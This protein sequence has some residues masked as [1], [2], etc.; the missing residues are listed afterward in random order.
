M[1]ISAD[2]RRLIKY[3]P[4]SPTLKSVV[5]HAKLHEMITTTQQKKLQDAL[6]NG[7]VAFF[8]YTENTDFFFTKNKKAGQTHFYIREDELNSIAIDA[9][10]HRSYGKTYD[11]RHIESD[12]CCLDH[13]AI[14][15]M[16]AGFPSYPKIFLVRWRWSFVWFW[17]VVGLFKRV[18]AGDVSIK[19]WTYLSQSNDQ[20]RWL[21][22]EKNTTQTVL[23]GANGLSEEVGISGLLEFLKRQNL[24]YI[25][26]R[27]FEQLPE[28]HRKGGDLDLMVADMDVERVRTF[29]SEHPG[30]VPIDVWSVSGR[31]FL[32]MPY[33]PPH[34]MTTI[35][36]K[37]VLHSSGARVPRDIDYLH[38]LMYHAVY[39]KGVLSGIPSETSSVTTTTLPVNDYLTKL[40]TIA[41][42]L[43]KDI[44][45][46]LESM[47]AYLYEQ[48]W[49]PKLDTLA[50]LSEANRWIQEYFFNKNDYKEWCIGVFICRQGILHNE[51]F[52]S[53]ISMIEDRGFRVLRSKVLTPEERLTATHH[54][55]GGT[56]TEQVMDERA[57]PGAVI[58]FVDTVMLKRKR[59]RPVIRLK[60]LKQVVRRH[61][62]QPGFNAVHSTDNSV[63]SFEYIDVLYPGARDDIKAEI[64]DLK[65]S[66]TVTRL[67]YRHLLNVWL[68]DGQRWL[69]GVVTRTR[70]WLI[71]TVLD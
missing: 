58:V 62:S 19:G 65:N 34:F 45:H 24:S 10:S 14:K 47:D 66:N 26:L 57:L 55:R 8:D 2:P 1:K 18:L 35:I 38:S 25:V 52:E 37:A 22:I 50:K 13:K 32:D 49:R 67:K 64:D 3:L 33:Y 15:A 5:S 63:E 36:E 59:P 30:P 51:N 12:V 40:T 39:H 7:D 53:I 17:G 9:N 42:S 71:S 20:Q 69:S 23:R 41:T 27:N 28:L 29:I 46:T 31:E 61:F 11:I 4:N 48:G 44:G 56:W 70:H 54:L 68:L 60:K 16:F 21:L 43:G 6:V